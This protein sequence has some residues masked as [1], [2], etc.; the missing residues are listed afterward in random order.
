[1]VDFLFVNYMSKDVA[2][3]SATFVK[4]CIDELKEKSYI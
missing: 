2:H 4:E 1:M 3:L